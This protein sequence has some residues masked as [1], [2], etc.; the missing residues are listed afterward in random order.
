M[1]MYTHVYIC[2]YTLELM[3]IQ[4]YLLYFFNLSVQMKY[5]VIDQHSRCFTT[6]YNH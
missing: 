3:I 4:V 5:Y 6:R 2:A 1:I